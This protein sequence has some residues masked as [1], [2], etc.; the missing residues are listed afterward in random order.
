MNES[1]LEAFSAILENIKNSN[2]IFRKLLGIFYPKYYISSI[3][4]QK[5]E[6]LIKESKSI[7]LNHFRLNNVI[8]FKFIENIKLLPLSLKIASYR[9]YFDIFYDEILASADRLINF[10][11][12]FI[13][14]FLG[15]RFKKEE[16]IEECKDFT[17]MLLRIL[18]SFIIYQKK[19]YIIESYF[20]L[21]KIVINISQH[22]NSSSCRF[23]KL[24]KIYK[25]IPK[26][27]HI[28]EGW[29]LQIRYVFNNDCEPSEIKNQ[30]FTFFNSY[31]K[32]IMRELNSYGY[33]DPIK[34][35]VF[36]DNLLIKNNLPLLLEIYLD[37]YKKHTSNFI[38]PLFLTKKYLTNPEITELIYRNLEHTKFDPFYLDKISNIILK[39][40]PSENEFHQYSKM[41]I[42]LQYQNFPS[43]LLYKILNSKVYQDKQKLK[44]LIELYKKYPLLKWRERQQVN[45]ISKINIKKNVSLFLEYIISSENYNVFL[46]IFNIYRIQFLRPN[47]LK[48]KKIVREFLRGDFENLLLYIVNSQ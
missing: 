42:A 6:R 5:F 43:D 38:P 8:F 31:K 14:N 34:F 44:L 23:L 20:K 10:C 27:F 24:F 3:N 15:N 39:H 19:Y 22:L 17:L 41:I 18:K 29:F 2:T 1:K 48:I 9:V 35:C 45:V 46:N 25:K 30:V 28:L 16:G 7:R 36:L 26:N 11:D 40:K 47:H 12:K 4:I 21:L 13:L 37:Y 32:D 33:P